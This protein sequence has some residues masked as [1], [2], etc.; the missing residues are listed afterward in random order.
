MTETADM[1]MAGRRMWSPS[2]GAAFLA[3]FVW[4]NAS[5][6]FRYFVILR[7][8][9]QAAFPQIP[10]VAPMN[11]P[12]FLSWGVWDTILVGAVTSFTW[13]YLDR[14]GDGIQNTLT[15]GALVWLAMFVLLW[16]GL[17]NMNLATLGIAAVAL[18][19]ALLEMLVA[20]LIVNWAR[21]RF[22]Y[23]T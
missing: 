3:N 9:L 18:P 8:M 13:A 14:F 7:S 21:K 16:L 15:A 11:L 23:E 22:P 12:I 1:T 17:L 4:V 19:L 2:F 5:E 10:D 6:V 20:A